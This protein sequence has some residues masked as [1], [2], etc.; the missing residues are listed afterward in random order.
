MAARPTAPDISEGA[1]HGRYRIGLE[2]ATI[3]WGEL[4][5]KAAPSGQNRSP[6]T[7]LRRG[8]SV[9]FAVAKV[10]AFVSEA[11]ARIIVG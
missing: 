6:I 8:C 2:A 5:S 10:F 1:T 9:A 4:T 7:S 11:I 3:S